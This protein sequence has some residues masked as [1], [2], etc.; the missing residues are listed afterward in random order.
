M[1]FKAVFANSFIPL[2]QVYGVTLDPAVL[3]LYGK[4]LQRL[5]PEQL[6]EACLNVMERFKPTA[7]CS[8]PTPAHFMEYALGNAEERATNAV[9]RVMEAMR[10]VGPNRS[11]NFGDKAL[12]RT[13]ERFGGWEQMRDMEWQFQENNFKKVYIAEMN[14]GDHFGPDYLPG[15]YEIQNNLTRHTWTRGEEPP[16]L[17]VQAG[18]SEEKWPALPPPKQDLPKITT[19]EA[20]P[21][22]AGE[23]GSILKQMRLP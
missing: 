15:C 13:I 19:G 10:R 2:Q 5:A 11:I 18:K 12:H 17:I 8:F 6:A 14:A 16:L 21:S 7:A 4:V 9:S 22:E 3:A 20:R 23:I 1:N